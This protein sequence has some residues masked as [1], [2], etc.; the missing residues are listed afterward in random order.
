MVW[1]KIGTQI[2]LY[3]SWSGSCNGLIEVESQYS[4][5]TLDETMEVQCL[6]PGENYWILIDGDGNNTVGIFSLTVSDGGPVPPQSET[7]LDEVICDG[8][9]LQVG[10]STYSETGL[11]NEIIIL[12]NGCDSFG[13]RNV[14]YSSTFFIND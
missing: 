10:D 7:V 6:T 5:A 11:I 4:S 9:T 12:P 1:I 3:E 13:Y 2:A 8:Q 14:D